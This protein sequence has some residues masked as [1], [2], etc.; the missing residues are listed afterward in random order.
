[1]TAKRNMDIK[2]DILGHPEI[3]AD[4]NDYSLENGV[5]GFTRHRVILQLATTQKKSNGQTVVLPIDTL[6]GEGG[7]RTPTLCS[8]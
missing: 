1:M 5:I 4:M 6:G 8:T 3:I 2:R 7:T